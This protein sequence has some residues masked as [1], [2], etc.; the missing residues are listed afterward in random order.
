MWKRWKM[1]DTFPR[2]FHE[3][4]GPGNAGLACISARPPMV[5]HESTA[6]ITITMMSLDELQQRPG[7]ECGAGQRVSM[8]PRG[9]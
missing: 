3:E 7:V 1:G 5:F 9:T 2:D 4:G 8:N 6:S